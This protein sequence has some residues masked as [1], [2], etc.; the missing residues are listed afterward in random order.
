MSDVSQ[1]DILDDAY[2]KADFL[3]ELLDERSRE[4]A[5]ESQRRIDLIRFGKF[6]DAIMGL[7]ENGGR[8][9]V[10]VPIMQANLEPYKIWFPIP[11]TEIELSPIEQ[12]PGY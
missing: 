7:D 12:N 11:L 3:E 10:A 2:Y 5:F 6:Y 9:N 1:V 4:F 8:W